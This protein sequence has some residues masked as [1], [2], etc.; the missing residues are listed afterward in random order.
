MFA[1]SDPTRFLNILLR[2]HGDVSYKQDQ[3]FHLELGLLKM[4]HA[5]RLLSVEQILSGMG[6]E[7]S[8]PPRLAAGAPGTPAPAGA[9][10]CSSP[11]G[12]PAVSPLE[13]ARSR[14]SREP[15]M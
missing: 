8:P 15:Q 7:P 14:K 3:R 11:R 13:S 5:Q 2:T 1:G 12:V 4:V 6:T 9:A 10:R